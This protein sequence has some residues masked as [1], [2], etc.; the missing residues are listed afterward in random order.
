MNYATLTINVRVV[1]PDTGDD[2][3]TLTEDDLISEAFEAAEEACKR[4][5]SG[6]RMEVVREYD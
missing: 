2:A 1:G 4:A 3:V 5:L 6:T